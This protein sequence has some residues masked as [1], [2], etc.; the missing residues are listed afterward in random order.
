MST[1][2]TYTLDFAHITLE[3]VPRVGG[4]NASLGQLFNAL[5]PQGIGVLDGF[6]TTVEA[7][8]RLLAEHEL[9]T[10]LHA[11]FTAFDAEDVH[12]LAQ[13]GTAARAAVL[14]TPLPDA[15]SA[16]ILTAYERLCQRVGREPEM[17]VRSVG[18]RRR[19]P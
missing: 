12:E 1:L 8:H 3:D 18:N 9:G 11:I 10:K 2:P 15:L 4:K 17:A 14:E 7:Y 5:K 13:R 19:S 16:S 6:A